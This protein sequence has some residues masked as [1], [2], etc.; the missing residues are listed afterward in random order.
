MDCEKNPQHLDEAAGIS[1][2]GGPLY[3]AVPEKSAPFDRMP[4]PPGCLA[5]TMAYQESEKIFPGDGRPP[6]S[7]TPG[8]SADY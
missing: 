2:K 6:V 7:N 1:E 8:A 5:G 4:F 3:A